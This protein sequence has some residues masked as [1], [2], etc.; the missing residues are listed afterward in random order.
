[1]TDSLRQPSPQKNVP[2][3]ATGGTVIPVVERMAEQLREKIAI[4][5]ATA[6]FEIW[7]K[8][9]D[10][11]K[12]N[13]REWAKESI[14]PLVKE[15]GYLAPEKVIK[16]TGIDL[17]EAFLTVDAL[18]DWATANGYVKLADVQKYVAKNYV[19]LP[20]TLDSLMGIDSSKDLFPYEFEG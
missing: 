17:E 3:I 20:K 2:T 5:G 12:N 8:L 15:A 9:S 14:L 7:D 10:E 6:Y 11:Q 1:M 4:E 18:R 13:W 19:R 16:V